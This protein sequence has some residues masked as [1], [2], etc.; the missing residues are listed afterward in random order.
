VSKER[1][2]RDYLDHLDSTMPK[3]KKTQ[4]K[5]VARGFAVTSMPKKTAQENIDEPGTIS[6]DRALDQHVQ[7]KDHVS[8][9]PNPDYKEQDSEKAEKQA[10]Q[11]LVDSLQEK[12]EKE[13]AR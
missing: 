13:I 10:L 3:K 1:F 9:T 7:Q 5:P 4:L 2:L 6:N 11:N 12:T 8:I